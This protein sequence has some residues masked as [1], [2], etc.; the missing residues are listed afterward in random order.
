MQIRINLLDYPNDGLCDRL[1]GF[2]VYVLCT[3]LFYDDSEISGKSGKNGICSAQPPTKSN[4][5]SAEM[6][7]LWA[8]ADKHP[9]ERRKRP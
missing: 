8:G 4:G 5:V 7:V 9:T 1:L 2:V 3:K 6:R